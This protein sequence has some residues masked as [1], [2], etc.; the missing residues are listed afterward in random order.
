MQIASYLRRN[1]EHLEK[2]LEK[3]L[4]AQGIEM[5]EV[6]NTNNDELVCDICEPLNQKE[7]GDGWDE[8]DGPPAHVRCRCWTNHELKGSG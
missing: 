3:E 5:I 2:F 6:W 7:K 1:P 8:S 4:A